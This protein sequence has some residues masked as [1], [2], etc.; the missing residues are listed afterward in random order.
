MLRA[1][2]VGLIV[3][4]GTQAAAA[5]T[6]KP[7]TPAEIAEA[8]RQLTQKREA[9]RLEAKAQKLSAYARHKYRV[10]CLKR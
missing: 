2:C 7:K 10:A 6:T 9:C 5:Q 4:A 3:I 8:S 1:I